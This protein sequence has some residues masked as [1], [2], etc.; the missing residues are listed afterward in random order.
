[1]SR[2][3]VGSSS[4]SRF[5]RWRTISASVSRAF[6]PPENRATGDVAMSPRKS[7]PPRKSR[8]S[9]S[10]VCGSRRARCHSGDSLGAQLLDLVL[11]E[12]AEPQ[13]LRERRARRASG[14]SVAGERLQQ[15]RLAGAVG[16]E[17]AD[18]RAGEHAP[19]DVARAPAARRRSRASR[20]RAARAARAG[21]VDGAKRERERA[22]DVRGGDQLHPL[23]RLDA[24]L[25]LLAPWSPWRG[26]GR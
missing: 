22:V 4:S 25:R 15:R 5:G 6:S 23:E 18:A 2:W 21:R 13:L 9:C 16:A 3:L 17:Q 10:R 14:A 11:R 26:S 19:V 20:A 24:A 1:M 12:V 7:K 8:S